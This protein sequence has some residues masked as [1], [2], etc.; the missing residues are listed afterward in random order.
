MLAGC[1]HLV[2]LSTNQQE[3]RHLIVESTSSDDTHSCALWQSV[4]NLSKYSLPMALD[5]GGSFIAVSIMTTRCN[6]LD[7]S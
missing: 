5:L 3:N 7:N 1:T 2:G 4:S 6:F